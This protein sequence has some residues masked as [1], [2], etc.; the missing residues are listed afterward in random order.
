MPKVHLLNTGY[1]GDGVA[2]SV[3]LIEADGALVVV[4][5]G[6]VRT[7]GA[8]LDPIGRLGYRPEEVTDVIISHH[9][10]DHTM[11]IALFR[12][13]SVHD[14]WATYREDRWDSRSAEGL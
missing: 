11:N 14:H 2:S 4:D 13:A 3:S 10:P 9:H 1:I 7:Q 5:P 8:I 12:N 6:M